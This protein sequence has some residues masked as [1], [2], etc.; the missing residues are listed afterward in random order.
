MKYLIWI[1]V[2]ILAATVVAIGWL[3]A[4]RLLGGLQDRRALSVV[5]QLGGGIGVIESAPPSR[6]IR[7]QIGFHGIGFAVDQLQ[8]LAVLNLLAEHHQIV[9]TFEDTNISAADMR[10][11]REMLPGCHLIRVVDREVQDDP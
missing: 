8:R 10:Q 7:Y 9:V 6:R 11:L 1:A 2:V 3:A 4:P 5:K